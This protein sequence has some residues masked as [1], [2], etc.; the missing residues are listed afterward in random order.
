[1]AT[2]TTKRA[3]TRTKAAETTEVVQATETKKVPKKY[4]AQDLIPCRSITQGL[5]LMPGKQSNILYRWDGYG[6]VQEVEYRDLYS[7]KSSRSRY[8]YDP[9]FIIEDEEL[10][11]DTRWKDVKTLYDNMYDSSDISAIINLTPAKFKSVLS[12]LPVGMKNAIK[13][14][15]ATRIND[16][17]F[18]SIKKIEAVDEICGTELK[19]LI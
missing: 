11:E 4:E 16:G 6:D 14:E 15:I 18:D 2:T 19:M 8:I 1:M 5:L 7:L 3:V 17:T 10:V 13:I 9:A 12:Q